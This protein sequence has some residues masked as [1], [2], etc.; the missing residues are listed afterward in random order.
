[1]KHFTVC[2][3]A[4]YRLISS[5]K[6]TAITKWQYLYVIFFKEKDK[7]KKRTDFACVPTRIYD[8]FTVCSAKFGRQLLSRYS[9]SILLKNSGSL[10][11]NMSFANKVWSYPRIWELVPFPQNVRLFHVILFLTRERIKEWVWHLFLFTR[12]AIDVLNI[13]G[14]FYSCILVWESKGLYKTTV[15]LLNVNIYCKIR[16]VSQYWPWLVYVN[17]LYCSWQYLLVVIT[18]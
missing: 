7:E 4:C 16:T 11:S 5:C 1:M 8:S 12:F 6:H 9:R 3:V 17:A 18:H 14:H 15:L 10:F 13:L 2:A